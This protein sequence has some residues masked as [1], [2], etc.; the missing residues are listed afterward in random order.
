MKECGAANVPSFSA[1]RKKQAQL[2]VD[3]DLRSKHHV[4]TLGNEFYANEPAQTFRLDWANPLVRPHIRPYVEVSPRL[5]EFYQGD[6]LLNEDVDLL[7]L[8]WADFKHAPKQHFYIKEIARLDDG[9]LVVPM[10]WICVL[11]KD[12][13]ETE[14]ADV[15]CV[16][17]DSRS[18]QTVIQTGNVL[19]IEAKQLHTNFVELQ[20]EGYNFLLN[21]QYAPEWTKQMPH[22]VREIAKGRATYT[23]SLMT[24]AD[25]VSGNRSKQYNAHTNVYLANLNIPHG[26][27]QQEYFV[28]FCSTSPNASALEQLEIITEE[29]GK[30]KWHE[31]Y[32]CLHED[33]ILF[34]IISRV[35]PADNPQQ[36]EECSHIG[37]KGNFFCRRC[38][39]GGD[40]VT[41]ET[42]EGYEQLFSPGRPRTVQ[43]TLNALLK[44]F[45]T[46]CMGTDPAILQK[47]SGVKDTIAQYWIDQTIP[48]A[49]AMYQQHAALDTR[50]QD[51]KIVGDARAAV[52]A[53]ITADVQKEMHRWLV[54]Q[55][56]HRYA[57]LPLDSPLRNQLRPGDHYNP[58]LGYA[59]L[60]VHRD[61]PVET[62]HTYSLGQ[63]KYGWVKTYES[64]TATELDELAIRLESSSIDGLSIYPVRG[65]YLVQY[66]N[67]LV[68]KHFK[69]LQQVGIFHLRSLLAAH[70]R[71]GL[72]GPYAEN[73]LKL[74]RVTGELGALLWYHSINDI[75]EYL[76]DLR[77][78]IDN[79]LD[80]WSAID[81]RRII[82]K[83]KLHTLPHIPSDIRNFGPAPLFSTEI[84]ECWNGIFRFCCNLSNHQA[85]SRDIAESLA[86]LERFKHLV[87]GGFWKNA[88]GEYVSA[89]E[90]IRTFLRTRKELQRR[91]GW[92][93]TSGLIPGRWSTHLQQA[94]LPPDLED[95]MENS[96]GNGPGLGPPQEHMWERTQYIVS[97]S[98]DACREK[99][100]VF[101]RAGEAMGRIAR[102]LL[103]V[104][105]NATSCS[106]GKPPVA[107]IIVENFIVASENNQELNM[108]VL[109]RPDRQ[110]HQLEPISDLMFIFNAQH[111]CKSAAC[112]VDGMGQVRQE[113]ILTSRVCATVKH[114]PLEQYFINMHGLHNAQL[115]RST[116]PRSLTKP[117]HIW[118]DRLAEHRKYAAQLRVTGP[119]KRAQTAAKAKET[120]A[121]NKAAKEAQSAQGGEGG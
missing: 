99:S 101:F 34:R 121:R 3:L 100:W 9:S 105:S 26:K 8:M 17:Y 50:L 81:P 11:D 88:M 103:P 57:L 102:I 118:Q 62:L 84:F 68:G 108:P 114:G 58:L 46:A 44:Q 109:L 47:E 48:K 6:R 67:V 79:V 31:A 28:R 78:L 20:D 32:D 22:P 106:S 85:P 2:V 113:R 59:G 66:K 54:Q 10:K 72:S 91:L 39:V 92:T 83:A 77:I 95:P 41:L 14:C 42:D 116:L 74:W 25:D 64:L 87:S 76:S 7:Q 111:D 49:K 61:T 53:E 75:D 104:T 90:N 89:G 37:L 120:R 40:A 119:Q 82:V 27:L 33:E 97:E 80:V 21:G 16:Q 36:S 69:A 63:T 52:K 96:S 4:S 5:S 51:R 18:G 65:R 107:V 1:L 73:L 35:K 24:W 43:G 71:V 12:G 98:G 15:H 23:L 115:I 60:D 19:R 94:D 93:E 110:A 30:D 112:T 117:T 45:E 55:P 29:T 13:G 56:P 38:G 70:E 86:G